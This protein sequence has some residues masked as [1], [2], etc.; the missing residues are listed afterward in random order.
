M[1]DYT[2]RHAFV[3]NKPGIK[4]IPLGTKTAGIILDITKIGIEINGYYKVVNE[5]DMHGNL[6]EPLIIS[7]ED[8]EKFKKEQEKPAKEKKEKK[9]AVGTE[10]EFDIEYLK[11]LPKVHLNGILYYIDVVNKEMRAVTSPRIAYKLQGG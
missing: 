6:R 8:L 9:K 5:G 3:D 7:W 1:G 10:T 4:R 2:L 11:T